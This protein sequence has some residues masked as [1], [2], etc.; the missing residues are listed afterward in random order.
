[1]TNTGWIGLN[2][3]QLSSVFQI[4]SIDQE[5]QRAASS[6]RRQCATSHP[7]WKPQRAQHS[8]CWLHTVLQWNAAAHTCLRGASRTENGQSS[9]SLVGFLSYSN[10]RDTVSSEVMKIPRHHRAYATSTVPSEAKPTC[11]QLLGYCTVLAGDSTNIKR[12]S[13]KEQNTLR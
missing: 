3:A 9:S 13:T 12:R 6:I 1:M 7:N 11:P 5:Y 10:G 2:S 4:R 8:S